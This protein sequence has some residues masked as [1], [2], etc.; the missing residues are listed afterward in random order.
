[1]TCFKKSTELRWAGTVAP[2][3]GPKPGCDKEDF[4]T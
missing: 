4:T 3:M 2:T 1:M